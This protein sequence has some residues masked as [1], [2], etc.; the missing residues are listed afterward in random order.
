MSR[1]EKHDLRLLNAHGPYEHGIWSDVNFTEES[2][3][4]KA[5]TLLFFSRSFDLVERISSELLNIYK[6]EDLSSMT[7]LDIGCYDAWILHQ[8]HFRFKFKRA[9]GIEPRKKNIQKGSFARK[10]Y[11]IES[12]IEILQGTIESAESVLGDEIFDIVLC[13]GTLHHVE[14]TPVSVAKIGALSRDL[15][16]IDSMVIEKPTRDSR[17]ILHLLNLKDIVYLGSKPDWAI[18]AFKYESPYLDGST[19]DANIVNVPEERLIRMALQTS[20]FNVISNSAPEKSFYNRGFQQLRGVKESFL[21]A[22]KNHGNGYLDTS[23][24]LEKA[25]LHEQI[26]LFEMVD[27]YIL[28][29]WFKK[30]DLSGEFA[31]I[32]AVIGPQNRVSRIRA[33]LLFFFSTNPVGP[34]QKLIISRLKVSGAQREIL[35]NI[36]RNPLDK[37]RLEV[38]KCLLQNNELNVALIA[39]AKILD[40]DGADW[41]SFY[42][43]CYLSMLAGEKLGD[44]EVQSYFEN[45][46]I[47]ANPEWPISK[48]EGLEWLAR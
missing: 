23:W 39:L 41:R 48:Q 12:E 38:G 3:R 4:D 37:I 36:S 31:E 28:E 47:I 45:L 1:H 11:G 27:L 42:R 20:A 46:L 7:I 9:V 19:A 17:K 10:Y 40:R 15:L 13:L 35:T 14:S 22:R 29:L 5:A 34:I 32:M 44:I 16:I 8:L 6:I 33:R 18:A 21:V 43:A 30:L 2:L 26:N 25:R 24:W